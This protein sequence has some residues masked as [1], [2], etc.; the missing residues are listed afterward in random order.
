MKI[1][2]RKVLFDIIVGKSK[3]NKNN[4]NKR[5]LGAKMEFPKAG[6][7]ILISIN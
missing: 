3:E 2:K 6:A 5:Q 1:K 7:I 4:K